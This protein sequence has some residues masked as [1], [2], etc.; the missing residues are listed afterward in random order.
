MK[1]TQV[2][3]L[4]MFFSCFSCNRT[5]AVDTTKT[6]SN[7]KEDSLKRARFIAHSDS[8]EN[9]YASIKIPHTWNEVQIKNNETKTL[10]RKDTLY[11]H[12]Q[13]HIDISTAY[14]VDLMWRMEDEK[15]QYF[16][17]INV[18][19]KADSILFNTNEQLTNESVQWIFKYINKQ[20][21]V[22]SW[23]MYNTGTKVF[24]V[25]GN[26]MCEKDKNE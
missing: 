2:L 24:V 16:N 20:K 10:K 8:A 5:P 1:L 21:T 15:I 23:S 12:Q 13:I 9:M 17:I 22:G 3:S 6:E 11:A 4:L 18:S 19:E 26:Y 7:R 25:T 14:Q